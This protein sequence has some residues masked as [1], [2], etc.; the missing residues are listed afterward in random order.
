MKKEL[1]NKNLFSFKNRNG[2]NKKF[3]LLGSELNI[4]NEILKNQ[5]DPKTSAKVDP[6]IWGTIGWDNDADFLVNGEI[7]FSEFGQTTDSRGV[8]LNEIKDLYEINNSLNSLNENTRVRE[9][10]INLSDLDFTIPKVFHVNELPKLRLTVFL[11]QNEGAIVFYQ[12]SD[13][14]DYNDEDAFVDYI[15]PKSTDDDYSFNRDRLSYSIPIIPQFELS[16]SENE[17]YLKM[18]AKKSQTSFI[19]KVLTFTREGSDAKDFLEIATESLNKKVQGVSYEWVHGFFGKKKYALRIFNAES[20]WIKDGIQYGGSF[21]IVGEDNKKIDYSKKTLLLL[22]GTWSNTFNSFEH[23]IIK[24]GEDFLNPSFLQ[25]LILNDNYEQILAFDRP[26]MSA[27]V[28]TNLEFFFD[29]VNGNKFYYPL[30]IVTTSQGAIVAEAL[31][32]SPIAKECFTIRRV[33]MFSAAN[34]CGYVKTGEN[35]GTLLGIFR[36]ISHDMSSKLILAFAQQSVNW[37]ISNPGLAQMHPESELLSKILN[38]TPNNANTE[39]IN[40]ISDWDSKLIRVRC[41]ALKRAPSILL[42]TIIKGS[43]GKKHDWVIGCD[44]QRLMPIKAVKKNEI[45]IISM[46]GKYLDLNHVL[47]KELLAY[48][49]F[50]THEMLVEQ[51]TN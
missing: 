12:H 19:V 28:Y 23:L 21:D 17:G 4:Q 9:R 31:S 47:R 3:L 2:I 35:I 50:N 40:V 41:A 10:Y 22:H 38:G 6:N 5:L 27:D 36:R 7:E 48:K 15:L 14:N 20:N 44:S 25:D 51:L 33:I 42:D 11:N 1:I 30:D 18:G 43:L 24:N 49:G 46:H 8:V 39:F 37:V 29:E 26:T 32:S 13:R 45:E 34:G 16:E